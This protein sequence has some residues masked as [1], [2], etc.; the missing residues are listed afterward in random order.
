M[1]GLPG[2]TPLGP[3]GE[4]LG[5]GGLPLPEVAPALQ[6]AGGGP[7]PAA[8]FFERFLAYSIDGLLFVFG[9]YISHA[10][11]VVFLRLPNIPSTLTQF[12]LGWIGAYVLYQTV[13][14]AGGRATLGK[15]LVGL[16][17]VT[18]ADEPLTFPRSFLRAV[19]Y[20][21]SVPAFNLG[22]LWALLPAHRAWHDYLAGTRVIAVHE[23][24]GGGVWAVRAASLLVFGLC[25]AVWYHQNFV[26]LNAEDRAQVEDARKMLLRVAWAQEAYRS[27]YGGYTS[28]IEDLARATGDPARFRDV[29]LRAIEAE[30]FEI[31]LTREGYLIRGVALNRQRTEVVVKGPVPWRPQ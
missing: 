31:Y 24:A 18:K 4:P 11:S 28:R 5:P 12:Q 9:C 23:R 27:V 26:A 20:F 7:E 13:F 3:D 10:L 22:F 21:I 1:S 6:D 30:G 17:V 29:L 14:N 19:G 8:G 2:I 25:C 16:R 15:L